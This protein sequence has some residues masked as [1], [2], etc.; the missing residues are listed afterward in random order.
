MTS[1][2]MALFTKGRTNF[3]QLQSVDHSH[4]KSVEL[5]QVAK[6]MNEVFAWF[7]NFTSLGGYTQYL[8]SK[9]RTSKIFWAILT[10]LGLFITIISMER[11]FTDL[12]GFGVTT[13]VTVSGNSSLNF[14]T[15]TLCNSNRVN[16][17]QLFKK[18]ENCKKVIKLNHIIL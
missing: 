3:Q 7:N 2:N 17:L 4:W 12:L 10:V 14:P 15:V 11:N 5:V 13:S 1:T 8:A 16:C 6:I 9:N 18:I